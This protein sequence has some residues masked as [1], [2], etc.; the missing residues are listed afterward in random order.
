VLGPG[1]PYWNGEGDG[2]RYPYN[3]QSKNFNPLTKLPYLTIPSQS[4]ACNTSL[5]VEAI[6]DLAQST[7]PT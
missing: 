3:I 1:C 4:A 7:H 5:S 6:L 2:Y